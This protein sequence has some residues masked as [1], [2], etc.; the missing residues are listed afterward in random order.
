MSA[1]HS[2]FC[3]AFGVILSVA[4]GDKDH[5]DA[6]TLLSSTARLLERNFS[7]GCFKRKRS[8]LIDVIVDE[9]FHLA[10]CLLTETHVLGN[11]LR[12]WQPNRASCSD[13]FAQQTGRAKIGIECVDFR[14]EYGE[15]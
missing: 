7:K 15:E 11:V 3:Y 14:L 13:G 5:L 9:A 2:S 1:A 12:F 8:S 10:A 6:K 4:P